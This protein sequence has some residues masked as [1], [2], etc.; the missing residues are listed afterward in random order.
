MTT[1]AATPQSV[2]GVVALDD[3]A[4]GRGSDDERLTAAMRHASAQTFAPSIGLGNRRHTFTTRRVLYDGFRLIGP[5]GISN[6][7]R[8]DAANTC[9]VDLQVDGPWL[10]TG[11]TQGDRWGVS[12]SQLSFLGHRGTQFLG[13]GGALY[14]A[15]LRDLSFTAFSS[16]L[17]SQASRLVLTGSTFDGW[18]E[19]NNSYTGAFHLAGSDNTL[20][21]GG[22]LLDSNTKY[23]AEGRATGQF[24]LWCDSLE[25]TVI[26]PLYITA[27][28]GWGGVR[29]TGAPANTPAGNL[30]G[31][32]VFP[33]GLRVEGRS[34]RAPCN[35]SLVRVEG[36]IVLLYAPWLSYAMADPAAQ[37]H[38][39]Q[40]AGVVHVTGG[41]VTLHDPTYDRAEGVEESVPLV[42][43]SGGDVRVD[44]V[45]RGAKGGTWKVRPALSKAG[46]VVTT[47]KSI[48]ALRTRAPT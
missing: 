7:E 27:E 44:G 5:P 6:A 47:D 12:I 20:W 34:A 4:F 29:V 1:V 11:L 43:A 10:D 30:G 17:G 13:G 40:D 32:L 45:R 36:G 33:P 18:W 3:P 26:G 41:Q 48:R 16:V 31:P 42:H 8:N 35:G 37:G 25:K 28:G 21:P 39:P 15:L 22:G 14:C 2:G 23:C 24:H 46:G 38:S 9:R 19:T